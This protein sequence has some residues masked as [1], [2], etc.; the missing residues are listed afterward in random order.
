MK[1]AKH[2][3]G[4]WYISQRDGKDFIWTLENNTNPVAKI[5]D[6]Y[7]TNST[8]NALLIAAAPELLAWTKE[9]LGQLKR[10][11]PDGMDGIKEHVAR[12]I[13][14]IEGGAK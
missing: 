13:A 4:P 2:T 1:H 14:R 3:P 12:L 10:D 9:L 6:V 8:P 5:F 11:H 7:G